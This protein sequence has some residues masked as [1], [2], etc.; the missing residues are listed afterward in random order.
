MKL[1]EICGQVRLLIILIMINWVFKIWLFTILNW[2]DNNN[3]NI[4]III[5][6]I[7]IVVV[8]YN[9]IPFNISREKYIN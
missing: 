9:L 7:I 2:D 3:N 6:I 5:I 4:I 1:V 8:V